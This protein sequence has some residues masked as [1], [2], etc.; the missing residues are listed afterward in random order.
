MQLVPMGSY[1]GAVVDASGKP[2]G[3][4]GVRLV[5]S[6]AGFHMGQIVLQSANCD[7][8][9]RF[10]FEAVPAQAPFTIFAGTP[11]SARG[12]AFS[13]GSDSFQVDSTLEFYLDPGEARENVRLVAIPRNPDGTLRVKPPRE[14]VEAHLKRRI[15]D[16]R[17]GGMR[18][19]VVLRGDASTGVAKFTELLRS[20][21]EPPEMLPHSPLP[22]VG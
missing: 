16:V 13:V 19:L 2:L 11:A 21:D 12:A 17:L 5:Y 6:G 20:T 9:G 1:R 15:R 14:S 18:L 10:N 7:E 3:E 4:H 22:R 8:R